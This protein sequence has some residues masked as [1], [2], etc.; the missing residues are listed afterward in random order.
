MNEIYPDY[1]TRCPV[2]KRHTMK[3]VKNTENGQTMTCNS[4][5]K[6]WDLIKIKD[7]EYISTDVMTKDEL[8]EF[9]KEIKKLHDG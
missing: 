2:E 9:K 1:P 6:V 3:T 8:E 7:G 5:G 4:C